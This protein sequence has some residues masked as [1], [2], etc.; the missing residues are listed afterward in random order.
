MS[1][2][3]RSLLAVALLAT[4]R[5]DYAAAN[6]PS[7]VASSSPQAASRLEYMRR[8]CAQY[9]VQI[10]GDPESATLQKPLLRWNDPVIRVLDGITVLWTY[11]GRPVA[12]ADVWVR[13]NGETHH[14]FQSLAEKSLTA[15]RDG[16]RVWH[17]TK[18]G[19]RFE[20]IP[21]GPQPSGTTVKRLA[22]M[23]A[24]ARRFSGHVIGTATEKGGRIELRL[25]SQPVY[26][27]ESSQAGVVDGAVFVLAKG[28]NPEAILLIE[29]V[30][31]SD[32]SKWR[33]GIA[34]KTNREIEVRFDGTVV[35]SLPELLELRNSEHVTFGVLEEGPA[36]GEDYSRSGDRPAAE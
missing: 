19:L 30:R 9:T 22:Q 21:G 18:P 26:R 33:V 2:P 25:L 34:P 17:P 35:L 13:P 7:T 23:R 5:P 12:A 16:K 24:L 28:T 4:L 20:P 32:E 36:W 8:E 3:V 10:G 11:G 1:P 29:A 27:Y 14:V 31:E 15:E 6:Q